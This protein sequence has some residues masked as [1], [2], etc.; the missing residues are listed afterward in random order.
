M[1]TAEHDRRREP[2]PRR[3]DRRVRRPRRHRRPVRGRA[4]A[5]RRAP[6]PGRLRRRA[7]GRATGAERH[8]DMQP[9]LVLPVLAFLILLALFILVLRRDISFKSYDNDPLQNLLIHERM[10]GVIA[11]CST[12]N[13]QFT[14]CRIEAKILLPCEVLQIEKELPGKRLKR[15]AG[16]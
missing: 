10:C 12:K 6:R 8:D 7:G 14:G 5:P 15:K 2:R 11:L 13:P 16:S 9:L 1:Q 3:P 4:R